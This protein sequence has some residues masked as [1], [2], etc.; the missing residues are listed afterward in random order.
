MLPGCSRVA[1]WVAACLVLAGF[2]G[3]GAAGCGSPPGQSPGDRGPG[4]GGGGDRGGPGTDGPG[5]GP[6]AVGGDG[7][8]DAGPRT[9]LISPNPAVVQVT[10]T[11][12]TVTTAPLTLSATDSLTGQVVNATWSI[13]RG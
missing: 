2:G 7:G 3:L 13:D 5:G 11:D 6:D 1:G 10:I 4:D 9:L 8:G 12:G